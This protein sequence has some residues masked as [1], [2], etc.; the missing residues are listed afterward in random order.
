MYLRWLIRELMIWSS[1]ITKWKPWQNH[2]NLKW[3]WSRFGKAKWVWWLK[4]GDWSTIDD[5]S[6]QYLFTRLWS[7]FQR[8]NECLVH[9]RCHLRTR[10]QTTS[11]SVMQKYSLLINHQSPITQNRLD[12]GPEAVIRVLQHRV[13]QWMLAFLIVFHM[14]FVFAEPPSYRV[15]YLYRLSCSCISFTCPHQH[16]HSI[17]GHIW[18]LCISINNFDRHGMGNMVDLLDCGDPASLFCRFVFH[19]DG[20]D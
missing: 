5:S 10:Y 18:P 17:V 19:D 8:K 13:F 9:W 4:I 2:G 7:L 16:H 20:W 6:C 14:C 1:K 12:K 15:S 3:R 11:V